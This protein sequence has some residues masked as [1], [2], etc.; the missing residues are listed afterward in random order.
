VACL[1]IP[2]TKLLL[3][4]EDYF[5]DAV[6]IAIWYV[7]PSRFQFPSLHIHSLI[8]T[9]S[10]VEVGLG[11]IVLSAA[12]YRPLCPKFYGDSGAIRLTTPTPVFAQN[13]KSPAMADPYHHQSVTS[14]V[15]VSPR[16]PV[17][18][19]TVSENGRESP[20]RPMPFPLFSHI[21]TSEGMVPIMELGFNLRGT[22]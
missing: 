19:T 16:K 1:R 12:A 10:I 20:S 13:E 5:F 6:P 17:F 7:P 15:Q 4:T 9:S 21:M 8:S 14:G 3:D 11:I 22:E 18:R 2:S